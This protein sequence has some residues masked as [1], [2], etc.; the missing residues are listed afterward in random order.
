MSAN[1]TTTIQF[2][3]TP[4]GIAAARDELTQ[5]ESL[6]AGGDRSTPM[7]ETPKGEEPRPD[8]PDDDDAA[9]RVW[10]GSVG[11]G[12]TRDLLKALP[13]DDERP[14]TF[15][16]LGQLTSRRGTM[17]TT[18]VRPRSGR[19]TAIRNAPSAGSKSMAASRRTG[20]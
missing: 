1:V 8:A 16:E 18:S 3:P 4:E 20:S 6:F 11:D 12:R 13:R 19:A 14:L 5:L 15:A 10:N 9:R 7:A 2:P 17:A